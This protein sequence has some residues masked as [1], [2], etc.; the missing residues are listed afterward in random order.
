MCCGLGL[1]QHS[2]IFPV[3]LH[4]DQMGPFPGFIPF[5]IIMTDFR[6]LLQI[7]SWFWGGVSWLWQLIVA[8]SW[9]V[10]TPA[11]LLP[12]VHAGFVLLKGAGLLLKIWLLR[13]ERWL[14]GCGQLRVGVRLSYLFYLDTNNNR[15]EPLLI[16]HKIRLGFEPLTCRSKASCPFQSLE[17][18]VYCCP[19]TAG[20][21]W[22]SE[23]ACF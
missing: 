3:L 2:P 6:L 17:N 7:L 5:R 12:G 1:C 8:V 10:V 22:L 16:I 11:C 18:Q 15:R 23:T 4:L 13:A 20:T 9:G 19:R 21:A 14:S